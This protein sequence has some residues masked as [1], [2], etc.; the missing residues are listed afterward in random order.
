MSS[1]VVNT[2][3]SP[4]DYKSNL[5]HTRSGLSSIAYYEL[6]GAGGKGGGGWDVVV[7]RDW[8]QKI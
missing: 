7:A 4:Q 6:V 3:Y 1:E 8:W 2:M 5:S